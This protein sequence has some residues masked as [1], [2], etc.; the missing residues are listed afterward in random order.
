MNLIKKTSSGILICLLLSGCVFFAAA[1]K[2]L[3]EYCPGLN[4]KLDGV[5]MSI[6]NGQKVT[7]VQYDD[8]WQKKVNA[9]FTDKANGYTGVGDKRRYFSIKANDEA[10]VADGDS[11]LTKTI[12]RGKK[13]ATVI[14]NVSAQKI[15]I[16]ETNDE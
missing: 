11:I 7:V 3:S 15:A 12:V 14:Y 1:G 16:V 5:S 6:N 4:I 10:I 2:K 8:S 9:Y 13:T